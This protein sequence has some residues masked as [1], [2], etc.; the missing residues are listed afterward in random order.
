MNFFTSQITPSLVVLHHLKN[1]DFFEEW[2]TEY[3]IEVEKNKL[4]EGYKF[5]VTCCLNSFVDG[6]IYDNLLGFSSDLIFNRAII[7]AIP[8]HQIENSCEKT[9]LLKNIKPFLKNIHKAKTYVEL[10]E[11]II[12]FEDNISTIFNKIISN[13][14]NISNKE[15]GLNILSI[16][17]TYLY[18]MQIGNNG[19]IG[20]I[21]TPLSTNWTKKEN[22]NN[23]FKGYKYS[24]Q[25]IWYLLLGKN[26]YEQTS[27]INLHKATSWRKYKY[28][29][30]NTKN[31][32][33]FIN[34][35]F[36]LEEQDCFDSYFYRIKNEIIIQNDYDDI[37]KFPFE[38][39]NKEDLFSSLFSS[40]LYKPNFSLKE[41][42]QYELLWYPIEII[43]SENS[44]IHSGVPAF[45]VMLSGTIE[46]FNPS[47]S[48][49]ERIYV[50]KFTHPHINNKSKNE[51]S[52][53]VL[54]D[55]KSVANFYSSGWII[56]QNLIG[57]Y[58]GGARMELKSIEKLINKYK[59]Y[60]ILKEMTISLDLFKT[61]TKEY[62]TKYERNQ[63][64]TQEKNNNLTSKLQV[65]R[66][67][68]LELFAYS[69]FCNNEYYKD[70]FDIKIN[71]DNKT[72]EKDIILVNKKNQNIK[73]I[74]CK[75]N[76]K[77]QTVKDLSEQ[78]NKKLNDYIN[79]NVFIELWFWKE[80]DPSDFEKI[81]RVE[82]N[83]NKEIKIVSISSKSRP[84]KILR[85]VN[86]DELKII[87]NDE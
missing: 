42:I 76:P 49:F 64:E 40:V 6:L 34:N 24:I 45:N 9:I 10:K 20:N 53:G 38:N 51:Y 71:V 72:N 37:I 81:N 73:I 15:V 5:A 11:K 23:Y 22:L 65:A 68:I 44:Q 48:E 62:Q 18:L 59:E 17:F 33:P 36:N 31:E 26:T 3:H 39:Y 52:F 7:N 8:I 2:L 55:T 13:N 69:I 27:L 70:N 79:N 61:I 83:I 41:K 66:G 56:Y 32:F 75:Y 58:S 82:K 46:L 78:L 14:I 57:D 87:M 12:I 63:I 25:F 54:I 19:P 85:N 74:E 43:N 29:E 86:I 28:I 77:T 1:I 16:N 4:F 21:I 67:Y 30:T 50:I 80:L 47:E 84:D 60:I 35:E